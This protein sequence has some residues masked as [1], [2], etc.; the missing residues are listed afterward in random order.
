MTK[1]CHDSKSKH[2][3][4]HHT[5]SLLEEREAS[6]ISRAASKTVHL[7]SNQSS[8]GLPV[9][10]KYAAS[11]VVVLTLGFSGWNGYQNTQSKENFAK[12]Q[13]ALEQKIQS[14]TFVINTPLPTIELTVQKEVAKPYHIIA[15]SFQFE[16]NATK[17]VAQLKANG[18]NA[19]VLGKNKWGLT[20]VAFESHANRSEAFKQLAT[21]RKEVAKDAWILIKTF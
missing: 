11:A 19:A 6:T 12:E 21:I 14:A 9:F 5:D 18:F 17:K 20:Q 10:V 13:K 8:K 15:G 4:L 7:P 16:E 1:E 2:E 3:S